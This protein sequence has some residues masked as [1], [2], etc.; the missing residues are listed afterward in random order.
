M[1]RRIFGFV[2]FGLVLALG[3]TGATRA[4][5]LE[6]QLDA[7]VLA[8]PEESPSLP[9]PVLVVNEPESPVPV[10]GTVRLAGGLQPFQAFLNTTNRTLVVP[11]GKR[12]VIEYVSASVSGSALCHVNFALVRTTVLV[13]GKEITLSHFVPAAERTDL[14]IIVGQET[15]F[16]ADPG[17]SVTADAETDPNDCDF[18]MVMLLSGH[19]EDVP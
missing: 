10:T 3:A 17:T 6:Q 2:S 5:D 16:Y 7:A 12:L 11:E 13:D 19:L 1:T 15:R 8:P 18:G 14:S 9:K 4:G